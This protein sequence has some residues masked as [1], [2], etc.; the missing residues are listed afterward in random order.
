MGVAAIFVTLHP[1][2]SCTWEYA[3]Q[4]AIIGFH[5]DEENDWSQIW[6]AVMGSMCGIIRRGK[7]ARG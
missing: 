5:L 3:M 6:P 4:Q 7:T 1:Q 2:S